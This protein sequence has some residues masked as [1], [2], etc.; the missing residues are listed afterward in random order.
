MGYIFLVF[1]IF[2]Q[3]KDEN[4]MVIKGLYVFFV[5]F[6]DIIV[7][8][9]MMGEKI[10]FDDYKSFLEFQKQEYKVIFFMKYFYVFNIDQMDFKE[11][12]LEWYEGMR[13][14]FF[15]FVVVDN[16]KGNRNF[17]LDKMIKEQKWFCFIELKVQDR[18]YYSLFKDRIV[19]LVLG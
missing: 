14:R 5:I 13:V 2:C 15:G 8:Y 11:K 18:V 6:Y 3:L 7:K 10:S 12:Y 1:M 16:V 17:W 9:K 4:L 19:F